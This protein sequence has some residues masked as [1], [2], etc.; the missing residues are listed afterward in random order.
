MRDLGDAGRW[1]RSAA[2]AAEGSQGRGAAKPLDQTLKKFK[3]L[4]GLQSG[5]GTT[6]YPLS[7]PR[8]S[9]KVLTDH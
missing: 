3:A 6:P 4:K 7:L 2:G 5:M 9:G 8:S 1:S